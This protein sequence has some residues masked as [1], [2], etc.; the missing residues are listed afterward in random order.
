MSESDDG[1]GGL[2]GFHLA[3]TP[4][5]LKSETDRSY[6]VLRVNTYYSMGTE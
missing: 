2:G 3:L 5:T 6:Y 4:S 1:F